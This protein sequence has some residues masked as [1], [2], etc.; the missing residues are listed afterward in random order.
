M[1]N[2]FAEI[3]VKNAGDI[4]KAKD[5]IIA[6]KDVRS[7]TMKALV[8]TGATTLIINEE[9]SRQLGLSTVATRTAN[10]AGGGKGSCNITEPVQI[11]WKDRFATVDA[12]AFPDGNPLLG[13]IP[14]EF[15]DLI[16]DPVRRELVGAHGD[17]AVMMAM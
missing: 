14:L 9:L 17:Q 10:L 12:I 5:G 8:D 4:I 15:M 11:Q 6:E 16:V 7:V 13:V 1:G 2:V 3:T